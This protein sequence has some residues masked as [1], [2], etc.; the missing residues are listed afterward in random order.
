[1]AHSG[2]RLLIHLLRQAVRSIEL[3]TQEAIGSRRRF[4]RQLIGA[5]GRYYC[6]H[7]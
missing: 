5:C 7:R 3:P 2:G 1:M 6:F 4:L